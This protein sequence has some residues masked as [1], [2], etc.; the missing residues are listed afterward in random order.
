MLTRGIGDAA[1]DESILDV[2]EGRLNTLRNRGW[3]FAGCD[4]VGHAGQ[5]AHV[6]RV[7]NRLQSLDEVLHVAAGDHL[8][9]LDGCVGTH[10][11]LIDMVPNV[12]IPQKRIDT[13]DGHHGTELAL[14]LGAKGGHRPLQEHEGHEDR[15][16]ASGSTR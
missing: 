9:T 12:R 7:T 1:L 2:L 16:S 10:C 6:R 11:G 14:G 13:N 5:D 15:G 3:T 8:R 4:E